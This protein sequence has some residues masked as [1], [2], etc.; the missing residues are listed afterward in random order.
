MS[1][2]WLICVCGFG[3]SGLATWGAAIRASDW[4]KEVSSANQDHVTQIGYE[5]PIGEVRG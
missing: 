3:R 5:S 2:W 1:G 4:H